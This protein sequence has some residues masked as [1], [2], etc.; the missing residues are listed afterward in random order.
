MNRKY[1]PG[2][3]LIILLELLL[4]WAQSGGCRPSSKDPVVNRG[5]YNEV[6]RA[7]RS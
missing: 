3:A 6:L 7:E 1:L 2:L 5:T 4:L